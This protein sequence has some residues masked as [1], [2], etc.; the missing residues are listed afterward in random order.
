[1]LTASTRIAAETVCDLL[2]SSSATFVVDGRERSAGHFAG[3][4]RRFARGFTEQGYPPGSLVQIAVRHPADRLALS[5]GAWWAGHHVTFVP[6]SPYD[7]RDGL[8]V[9]LGAALQVCDEEDILDEE[10]IRHRDVPAIA[11]A[12]LRLHPAT[13]PPGCTGDDP[14]VFLWPARTDRRP[15]AVT[16]AD[17]VHGWEGPAVPLDDTAESPDLHSI[18]RV[19]ATGGR[20]VWPARAGRL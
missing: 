9:R 13:R 6:S 20:L 15:V 11:P 2:A 18:A 5:C 12:E 7:H 16:Q 4:A 19:L 3:E 14:A 8:A 1:V 10:H 17:L